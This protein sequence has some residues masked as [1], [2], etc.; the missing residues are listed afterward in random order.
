MKKYIHS[1]I[2]KGKVNDIR[3]SE[4]ITLVNNE[5]RK[6]SGHVGH[7]MTEFEKGRIMVFNSNTSYDRFCGHS[8]Y[9]WTEYRI[10]DDYGESFGRPKVFPYSKKLFLDGVNS[11]AVEKAVTCDNGVIAAF[12]TICSMLTAVC[13]EPHGSPKVVL[14]YDGGKSWG[15]PTEVSPY[16]GRI[17]DA[18]YH[19]GVCYVLQHCNDCEESFYATKPEHVYRIFKSMDNCKTF[20]EVSIVGFPEINGRAYGNMIFTPDEKLIV[21][22]YNSNDELNMDYC[23]SEDYGKTWT[24]SGKSFL[25]NKIRNPQVGI[26]DGQYI[27]HG[28]AGESEAGNGAF[29]IYTSADGLNWDDGKI[30]VK[31]RPACFYSENL[32]VKMPNGKERMYIKYSENIADPC[33]DVWSARVNGMLC[34]LETV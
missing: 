22:A 20:E 26:L 8:N 16:R 13:F 18:L 2:I 28:R 11:A 5:K 24:K 30:L 25:M 33:D 31:G 17:F 14:S 32:T 1:Q 12:T 10:S 9:G 29:V 21:Y 34:Y 6:R 3:L 15:E 27:L 4:P 23:I 7:A 19:K